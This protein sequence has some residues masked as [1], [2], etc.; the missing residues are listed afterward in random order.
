MHFLRFFVAPNYL[1]R[2]SKVISDI[3]AFGKRCRFA[4]ANLINTLHRYSAI[5][6]LVLYVYK[7]IRLSIL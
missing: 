4:G 6:L 1:E 5:R 3:K 7:S 2:S